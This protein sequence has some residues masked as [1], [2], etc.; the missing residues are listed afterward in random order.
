M[1]ILCSYDDVG[2]SIFSP[3]IPVWTENNIIIAGQNQVSSRRPGGLFK[4]VLLGHPS[5]HYQTEIS[6]C[7]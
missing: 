1:Y 4:G 5:F 6:L 7:I 3:G 2:R